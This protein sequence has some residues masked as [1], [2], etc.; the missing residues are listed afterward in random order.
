ME[1]F[2]LAD[3]HF[4]ADVLDPHTLPGINSASDMA[5]WSLPNFTSSS[6]LSFLDQLQNTP[7]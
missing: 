1:M 2:F 4:T 3:P 7:G 5:L 6:K